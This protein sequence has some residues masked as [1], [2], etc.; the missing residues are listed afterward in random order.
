VKRTLVQCDFDGTITQED[1]S[2]FLLD[3]FAQGDWR[4]LLRQYR[5]RKLSVGQFNSQAF[6][7]IKADKVTLL[8]T[9]KDKVKI[10]PGF[11]ELVN[12]CSRRQ[13]R[14]VIVSN[15]LDFY[16][17]AILKE[18]G[19]GRVEFHAAET[20]FTP[21]GLKVRYI[22]PEGQ[23]LHS[24]FKEAYVRLFLGQGYRI[25]YVGNGD[26]DVSPARL[27]HQ[28]LARGELLSYFQKNGLECQ[29]FENLTDVVRALS[30]L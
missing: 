11:H 2:F 3:S 19:L 8:E 16:I 6:A 13:F 15:G 7:L 22:G 28:V 12:Y 24:D 1:T 23:E 4:R 14:F 25:I 10:R 30:L 20:H 17:R 26:S 18:L 29:P 27:A 21:Q 9:V 5:E